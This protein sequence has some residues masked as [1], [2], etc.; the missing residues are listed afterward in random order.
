MEKEPEAI[1]RKRDLT[2]EL[3]VRCAEELKW[4][5][6]NHRGSVLCMVLALSCSVIAGILG[7]FCPQVGSKVVGG[8]ALLPP[9]VAFVAVNL[10][11]EGKNSWHA[12]LYDSLN[13]LR[14]R[15]LYQQ[16]ETPSLD[17][18]AEIAKRR[19]DLEIKMQDEWDRSL[20]ANWTGMLKQHQAVHQSADPSA[21]QDPGSQNSE[22]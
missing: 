12:R 20:L 11:F 4:A 5:K 18:V 22:P 9:L 13:T 17:Q 6:W 1:R 19:D 16:P 3:E 7:F 15:L 2:H 8:F 10:K 14:S 21:I